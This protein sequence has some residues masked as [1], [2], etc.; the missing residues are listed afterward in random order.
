MQSAMIPF[1]RSFKPSVFVLFSHRVF[2]QRLK[3]GRLAAICAILAVVAGGAWN[4]AAAQNGFTYAQRALGSGVIEPAGVAIDG[5]GN[6]LVADQY[7]MALR[8]IVAAGGYTNI[9]TIAS[10]LNL[11]MGVAVDRSGN[12]FLCDTDNHAVKE[13]A[14]AGGVVSSSSTVKTVA[15]GNIIPTGIAVDGSGNVF[16]A[17]VASDSIIEIVAVGG[18]VSSTSAIK[19]VGS[20][21]LGP[22]GVAVDGSGNV[23]VADS[24]NNA[25]E[26]IVAVGGVVSSTSTVKTVGS[27]FKTPEGVAVDGSGNVFVGDTGNA[28]VKEI[29]AVGG[30]VSNSS[31]VKAVGS[32]FRG[33]WGLAVD[34]SG[35]VFVADSGNNAVEEVM[36]GPVNFGSQAV[37]T[38]STPVTMNFTIPAGAQVGSFVLTTQGNKNMDFADAGSSTC[39]AKTYSTATSCVVNV[40]FTPQAPGLRN[41]ALAAYDPSGNLMASW[42]ITGTGLGPQV[43][44]NAAKVAAAPTNPSLT[45]AMRVQADAQGNLFAAIWG[46]PANDPNSGSI[47]EFKKNGSSYSAGVAVVSGLS[48]PVDLALDGA[49]NLLVLSL[50]DAR[51]DPNSGSVLGIPRTLTGYS[52][53]P[54]TLESGLNSP[55]GLTVDA[56]NDVFVA[57]TGSG[58]VI[59]YPY[60][61]S[62]SNYGSPVTLASGL[63]DPMGL[64]F[65]GSGD[66]FVTGYHDASKNPNSGNVVALPKTTT[67]FGSVVTVTTGLSYPAGV[68]VDANG[69]VFVAS[70]MDSN[71][72]LNSGAILEI[73]FTGSSFGT[74]ISLASGMTYSQGVALDSA[75]NIFFQDQNVNLLYVLPRATA[76]SLSFATTTAGSSSTDSPQKIPVLNIGNQP[77]DFSSV[78]YPTDFPETSYDCVQAPL[79]ANGVCTLTIDF[80]PT[81]GGTFNESMVLYDNNLNGTNAKQTISLSGTGLVGTATT[82]S[83]SL[84]PSTY[85]QAVT[86]TATVAKASGSVTPTGTVQFSVDGINVGSAVTLSGGTAAFSISTLATGT[87]SIAAVYT[88]ATGNGFGASDTTTLSQVVNKA[89][90]TS[91]IVWATP[92]AIVYPTALSSAQLDATATIPGSFVYT[93]AA[94]TV[95]TVGNY[96]L[97]VK[98]TPTD[99][100]NYTTATATVML[101]VNNPV[102]VINILSPAFTNAGDSAFTLTVTGSGFVPISTIYWG[103][104][105]LATTYVSATQLTAQVSA[106]YIASAGI[107]TVSVQTPSTAPGGGIS[108]LMQFEVD[109]PGSTTTSP[110]FTSTTAATVTAGSTANYPVTLPSNVKSISVTCLNLPGGASCSYSQTTKTVT[111]TTSATTPKGTYRITV[112]FT[113]TVVGVAGAG[114]LLPIL[115]LPL[116]FIRRKLAARGAWITACLGIVLMT[117]AALSIGCSGGGFPNPVQMTSSGTVDITI[118]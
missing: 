107:S 52:S 53:S 19:T 60:T 10:G 80:S 54:V 25:V 4:M 81:S 116:L 3:L 82:L 61:G 34:G 51:N 87:H 63:V 91:Y 84:N 40:N 117:A 13:I 71:Q 9:V 49:G 50:A 106:A 43:A 98:F 7:D 76:P 55:W 101:T 104:T 99:P 57:V 100:I 73:P 27:G 113:E 22:R 2:S 75:G 74:P 37:G 1:L 41:G 97:S 93:P 110:T 90:S 105:A 89:P 86:I 38:T 12:V 31:P 83:S 70:T 112:I 59:E 115:L 16:V 67:G 20:G 62:G 28:A 66:L 42:P 6:I 21:F 118:Q 44:F 14:A 108:D 69:N 79:E 47:M 103:T 88:P 48:Q 45:N 77:L 68:A 33:P 32:G 26:E 24:G 94:G 30:V 92:A 29:M 18:I 11:P 102:P 111:I 46:D 15:S 114:I 96:T 65:D 56:A 39:T 78:A 17:D 8:E 85:G 72:D 58:K 109:T 95:L 64:A 36:T 5:S 35:N 23:F